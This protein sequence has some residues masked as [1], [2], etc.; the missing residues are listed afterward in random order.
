MY[1]H[2]EVMGSVLNLIH[3]PLSYMSVRSV[4]TLVARVGANEAEIVKVSE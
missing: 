3:M 4:I 2:S 1:K